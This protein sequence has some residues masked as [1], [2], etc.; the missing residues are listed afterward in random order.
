M[1]NPSD[2]MNKQITFKLSPAKLNEIEANPLKN[3]WMANISS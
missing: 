3:S 2:E 1:Q